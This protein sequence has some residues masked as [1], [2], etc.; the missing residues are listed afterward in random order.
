MSHDGEEVSELIDPN[1]AILQ[2]IQGMLDLMRE[3]RQER[4]AHQQREVRLFQEDEG[5]FDLNAHERQLGG[6]ENVRG[7][8][9][10]N[11]ANVMQPR[12]MKRVHEDRDEGVKLKIPHF[13]GMADS[14]TYLQWE[15][16][17]EHVFYS[18]TFSENKKM[19]L[20]IV[21][22]TNYASEWYHYL[23]SERRRKEEDPIKTCEELKEAM[24]KRFVQKHYER[25]L[26][27]LRQGTKSVAEYYREM[28]TFIGR[29]RIQKDKED[30]MSRE[31]FVVAKKVETESSNTKKVEASKEVREKT[32]SIQCWKCKGFG[33][34]SKDCINKR[35]MVVRNGVID[36]EDECEENDAQL[37]EEY[38]TPVDDEYIEEGNSISLITRWV[39]N[40]KIKEEKIED[41]RK[42]LFHTKCLIEGSPCSLVI[43]NGSC[44]NVPSQVGAT[45]RASVEQP[46]ATRTKRPP[47]RASPA[48]TLHRSE[49]DPRLSSRQP[50]FFRQLPPRDQLHRQLLDQ[51]RRCTSSA[52]R[53]SLRSPVTP[54]LHNPS[55]TPVPDPNSHAP[56]STRFSTR[57][58]LRV[59]IAPGQ[60]LPSR[61]ARVSHL[62]SRPV[63]AS[64]AD[65]PVFE[66]PT[67]F[68]VLST[69]FWCMLAYPI[70]VVPAWP[71]CLSASF[72]YAADQFV[73][74]VPLG[75]RR[76]DFV[77]TGS[78]VARVRGRASK[79]KGKR[80]EVTVASHRDLCFHF[81][82]EFKP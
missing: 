50:E 28:E 2:A 43:D 33:H 14:E 21:E 61:P 81:T 8:G 20:A 51:P 45:R 77:P 40:V 56:S 18:N 12:R 22:F 60:R 24:R 10:N 35:V 39:L 37:E 42:N 69:Y 73:L 11:L 30:T 54:Y 65:S 34:M 58:L 55:R 68:L 76:P 23:K 52:G 78:H 67:C 27:T 63:R 75:H 80:P 41:Q 15:R 16:K 29:A 57:A 49:V 26:K 79:G 32:S 71:D 7:R 6:R 47:T 70:R 59:P 19:K 9:R 72:G 64:R 3:E 46:S 66:P 74:G 48:A 13:T 53:R 36:S 38:E 44:T 62:P 5:M 31:K 4:R 82:S 17:I 25:D 1:V